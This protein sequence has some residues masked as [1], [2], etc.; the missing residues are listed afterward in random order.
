MMESEGVGMTERSSMVSPIYLNEISFADRKPSREVYEMAC[1]ESKI[2][3]GR[4][5]EGRRLYWRAQTIG[6]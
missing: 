3:R 6:V 4:Y 1:P 2:P 5:Y